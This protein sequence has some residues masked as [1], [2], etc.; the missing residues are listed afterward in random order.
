MSETLSAVQ[1]TAT[2]SS[3]ISG[4]LQAMG[5]QQ[6][7][8]PEA[9]RG[10]ADRLKELQ[11]Q[12]EA[13]PSLENDP[14]FATHV[15]WLMQDW[16]KFSGTG[17][18]VQMSPLLHAGLNAMAGQY[19]G[20]SNPQMASML[21]QTATMNDRQ[22]VADIRNATVELGSLPAEQQTSFLIAA[23][24]NALEARAAQAGVAPVPQPSPVQPTQAPQPAPAVAPETSASVA[25]A[26]PESVAQPE[27]S[28]A[29]PESPLGASVV[30]DSV[31]QATPHEAAV[32]AR[33]EAGEQARPVSGPDVDHD[34]PSHAHASMNIPFGDEDGTS[35]PRAGETVDA[36]R[37]EPKAQAT[38]PAQESVGGQKAQAG[39]SARQEEDIRNEDMNNQQEAQ[40]APPENQQ[41]TQQQPKQAEQAKERTGQANGQKEQETT[42]K[43]T[44]TKEAEGEQLKAET[45]LGEQGQASA[46]AQPQAAQPAQGPVGS[47]AGHAVSKVANAFKSWGSNQQAASDQR[48][49]DSLVATVDGN[50][51]TADTHY[52]DLKQTAAP[53]FKKMEETAR[54][55]GVKPAELISSMGEGGKHHDLWQEFTKLRL[56]D[57]RVGKAYSDLGQTM[58]DMR[59]NLGSL[60]SEAAE[61]GAT[62]AQSVVDV[63]ERAG[64]KAMEMEDIPGRNPGESLIKNIGGALERIMEK[65]KA[66]FLALTQ[67]REQG[68]DTGPSMGA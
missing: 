22:L 26:L 68:R 65:V 61:R 30:T 67:G 37:E 53:F 1:P 57:E 5:R 9:Q 66:R 10:L 50:I 25:E 42:L 29:E 56:S 36:T 54:Q 55:E 13:D 62:N 23:G 48:R 63:E 43:Q 2:P 14:K 44:Q 27:P 19:P 59:R 17:Q 35:A 58:Q 60:Q 7:S 39:I 11:E 24:V 41:G 52:Q 31:T 28:V 45:T 33:Q 3:T 32:G 16:P 8:V 47:L 49:I 40:N 15:A 46:R 38:Q 21:Q 64:K 6:Q 34:D 18:A 20:M 12:L 51:R 4:V